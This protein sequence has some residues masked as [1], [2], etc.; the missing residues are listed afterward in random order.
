MTE[1]LDFTAIKR[2]TACLYDTPPKV[3]L[4]YTYE[5]EAGKEPRITDGDYRILKYLC[6]NSNFQYREG[7]FGYECS[8]KGL[9]KQLGKDRT[10][11]KRGLSRLRKAGAVEMFPAEGNRSFFRIRHFEPSPEAKKDVQ[12]RLKSYGIRY[13]GHFLEGVKMTPPKGSK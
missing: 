6:K 11:I 7:C 5:G 13:K 10:S 9:A 2:F 8:V 12:A 1:R 3:W 4:H